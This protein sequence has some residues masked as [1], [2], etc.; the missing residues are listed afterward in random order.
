M[1]LQKDNL[2]LFV[3][4]TFTPS[5]SIECSASSTR[6]FDSTQA[7]THAIR[8]TCGL[9]FNALS[10]WVW[11]HCQRMDRRKQSKVYLTDSESAYCSSHSYRRYACRSDRQLSLP[12]K[13]VYQHAERFVG[14]EL[15]TYPGTQLH[16]HLFEQLS[17]VFALIAAD[18]HKHLTLFE[19]RQSSGR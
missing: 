10:G 9:G 6:A 18:I 12:R 2:T 15:K 1:R 17:R 5:R 8:T 13:P 7:T 11:R 16:Q 3:P 14:N 4:A 19:D